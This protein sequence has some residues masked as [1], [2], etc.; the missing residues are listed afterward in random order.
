MSTTLLHVGRAFTPSTEL[1]DAGI[2][3]RDGVIA[4][5][6]RAAACHFPPVRTSISATDRIAVPG[7]LDVHIHG[8]GGHDVM[9][10]TEDA[11]RLSPKPS[12]PTV[13]P[14]TLRRRSRPT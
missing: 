5:I 9:E 6:G 7:F 12:L 4:A 13:P 11:L 2:L 3:V 1:R 14:L 8:A 10:G